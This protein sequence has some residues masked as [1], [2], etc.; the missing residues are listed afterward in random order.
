MQVQGTAE[1]ADVTKMILT[2]A[3]EIRRMRYL[4]TEE[5]SLWTQS[6]EI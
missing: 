1:K 5:F 3:F 6:A 2:T 4:N